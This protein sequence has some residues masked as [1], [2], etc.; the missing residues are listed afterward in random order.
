MDVLMDDIDST[1]DFLLNFK[2]NIK[3]SII[4]DNHKFFLLFNESC[5]IKEKYIESLYYILYIDKNININ[6]KLIKLSNEKKNADKNMK[7]VLPLILLYFASKND[8]IHEHL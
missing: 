7:E 8:F 2:N 3:N 4:D 1:I 6:N 5:N